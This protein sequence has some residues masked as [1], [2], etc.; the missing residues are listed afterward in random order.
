[1]AEPSIFWS[2]TAIV[3]IGYNI[4]NMLFTYCHMPL[5]M[6]EWGGGMIYLFIIHKYT[7]AVFKQRQKRASDPITGGCEPPVIAG[8]WTQGLWKSS[9]CSYLLSHLA[10][11]GEEFWE[12]VCL[13][14]HWCEGQRTAFRSW[15][16][17]AL[18]WGR[19]TSFWVIL[20]SLPPIWP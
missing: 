12:P 17:P 4:N 11:P 9:Q 5:P 8:I 15:F 1:M 20:L 19:L 3:S 14:W 7:V 13:P 6:F 2:P 16:S 10:S 18:Q